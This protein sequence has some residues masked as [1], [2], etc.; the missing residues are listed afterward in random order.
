MPTSNMP[1]SQVQASQVPTSQV[2]KTF[3]LSKLDQPTIG[4]MLY[5]MASR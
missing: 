5:M 2:P 1:T 4:K 3:Y